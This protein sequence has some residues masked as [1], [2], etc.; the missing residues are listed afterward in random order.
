MFDCRIWWI[1]SIRGRLHQSM[2]QYGSSPDFLYQEGDEFLKEL[3]G[4]QLDN[5]NEELWHQA[6]ALFWEPGPLISCLG[7]LMFLQFWPCSF[8]WHKLCLFFSRVIPLWL[9]NCLLGGWP[10]WTM[11]LLC[12]WWLYFVVGIW[13]SWGCRYNCVYIGI[14]V[15]YP[16]PCPIKYQVYGNE[17][18]Q[19]R[20]CCLDRPTLAEHG[21]TMFCMS[22]TD[23]VATASDLTK[24]FSVHVI[25]TRSVGSVLVSCSW[26]DKD[27]L[28]THTQNTHVFT[29]YNTY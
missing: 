4:D 7:I 10:Q 3:E 28:H 11:Q 12:S 5:S 14:S 24:M 17:M 22:I 29:K 21:R 2:G 8:V 15:M 27:C 6:V 20:H 18:L 16:Q 23:C 25:K 1:R 13:P 19:C 26:C 9:F